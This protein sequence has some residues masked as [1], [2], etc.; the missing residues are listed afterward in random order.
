[1]D[2][3]RSPQAA[4]TKKAVQG[5]LPQ[6]AGARR[7][8]PSAPGNP[9][10][11]VRK[12][13]GYGLPCAKCRL[14]YPAD[15]DICPTCHSTERVAP[16]VPAAAAKMAQPTVESIPDS[17]TLEQERGNLSQAISYLETVKQLSPNPGAI[18]KQIDEI[19]MKM[20][21]PPGAVQP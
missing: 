8:D 20:A 16:I 6:E 15:L 17:A 5:V 10:E 18:Q 12:P 11:F 3:T 4:A 9:A 1:M 13:S 21:A 14:Y 7:M 2:L 19:K